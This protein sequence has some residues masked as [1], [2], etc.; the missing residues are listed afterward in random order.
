MME[1]NT[2]KIGHTQF[3]KNNQLY[4]PIVLRQLYKQD[5]MHMI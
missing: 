1:G 4:V 5:D 2:H 3:C